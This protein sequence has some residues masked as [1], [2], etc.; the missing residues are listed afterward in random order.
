MKLLTKETMRELW[1]AAKPLTRKG[2]I[3]H[4]GR[5]SYGDYFL[6]LWPPR[7]EREP[8]KKGTIW[9]PKHKLSY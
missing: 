6:E 7:G 1:A 4:V 5:M 3:Y 2:K 9:I 8:L